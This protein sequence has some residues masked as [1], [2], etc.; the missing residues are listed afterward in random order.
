MREWTVQRSLPEPPAA[1]R[2]VAIG[3]GA[4]TSKLDPPLLQQPVTSRALNGTTHLTVSP[5]AR[6]TRCIRKHLEGC[7]VCH[8]PLSYKGRACGG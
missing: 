6:W 3:S 5:A 8:G 2:S 1:Y 4:Q 7:P